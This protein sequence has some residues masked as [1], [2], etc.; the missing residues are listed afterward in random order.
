MKHP[1][2][3]ERYSGAEEE[4]PKDILRMRY[5][6]VAEFVQRF[7]DETGLEADDDL[8]LRNRPQLATELYQAAEFL[9]G[10]QEHFERAW[11]ICKPYMK[12]D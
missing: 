1:D 5:D 7:A 9:R 3:V 4:L 6:C 12:D 8:Y 2:K 10:A 11:E